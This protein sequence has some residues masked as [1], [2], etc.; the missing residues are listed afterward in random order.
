MLGIQFKV[1]KCLVNQSINQL[2]N[3]LINQSINQSINNQLINQSIIHS[4][5][6]SI[7]QCVRILSLQAIWGPAI[8]YSRKIIIAYTLSFWYHTK[9]YGRKMKENFDY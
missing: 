6:Q 2:I 9:S 3:Q 5:N 4:L 8:A 1:I 7:N